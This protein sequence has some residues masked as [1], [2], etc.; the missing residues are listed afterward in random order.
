MKCEKW[1]HPFQ[2]LWERQCE[3]SFRNRVTPSPTT[4]SP[5]F[6]SC[7]VSVSHIQINF[8]II[9]PWENVMRWLTSPESN[10]PAYTSL[11]LHNLSWDCQLPQKASLSLL[12][13]QHRLHIRAS[14]LLLKL[15]NHSSHS[16]NKT[17]VHSGQASP[18]WLN[19]RP[20]MPV[21]DKCLL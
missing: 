2:L 20:I 5:D 18:H 3:H 13:W 21:I 11:S 7:I 9:L 12:N 10:Y 4:F 19:Q 6:T 15:Q 16:L 14:F 8:T 1:M 17:E